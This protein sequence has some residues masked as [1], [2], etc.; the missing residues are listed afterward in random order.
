MTGVI[1]TYYSTNT[2]AENIVLE[3]KDDKIKDEPEQ[4]NLDVVTN[5]QPET[6][7]YSPQP[8]DISYYNDEIKGN[9]NLEVAVNYFMKKGLSLAATAG[10]VANLKAES[11]LSPRRV[12][13]RVDATDTYVPE[14]GIG[15]GIAQWTTKNRQNSIVEFANNRDENITDL[16]L[17]LDFL[18]QEMEIN[19]PDMLNRLKSIE[20]WYYDPNGISSPMEA[21]IIFHGWTDTIKNDPVIRAVSPSR[22]YEGSGDS[23]R[24][25]IENRGRVAEDIFYAYSTQF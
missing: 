13:S 17:Q 3:T 15:F 5:V 7:S 11:G 14:P 18:W 21:A 16:G 10:I 20:Y 2:N 19:L 24:R 8:V 9:K 12:Q 4:S 23:A 1:A 6:I 25:I 22:G